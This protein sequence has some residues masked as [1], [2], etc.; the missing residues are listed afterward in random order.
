LEQETGGQPEDVAVG[1]P[2]IRSQTSSWP[3]DVAGLI[4]QLNGW[5]RDELIRHNEP[6][7]SPNQKTSGETAGWIGSHIEK[8]E[9]MG[10]DVQWDKL[11]KKYVV[12]EEK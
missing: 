7:S 4:D 9:K 1:E 6:E 8:L 2:N 3:N 10:V 11:Q 12:A 5:H